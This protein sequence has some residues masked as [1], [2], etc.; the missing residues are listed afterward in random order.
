MQSNKNVSSVQMKKI[1]GE[2]KLQV[3]F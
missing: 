3:W 1:V 2:A